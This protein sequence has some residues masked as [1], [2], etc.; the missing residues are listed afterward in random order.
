MVHIKRPGSDVWES[1][2]DIGGRVPL[3]DVVGSLVRY[4]TG[5]C[6]LVLKVTGLTPPD[7]AGTRNLLMEVNSPEV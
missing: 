5:S 7:A 6:P 4:E 1:G 3:A 2:A